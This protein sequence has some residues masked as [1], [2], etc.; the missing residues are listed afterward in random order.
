M[1]RLLALS[2]GIAAAWTAPVQPQGGAAPAAQPQQVTPPRA[3][4]WMGATTGGGIL[5]MAGAGQGR[6]S[7][8]GM[9]R[10]LANPGDASRTV[11]LRLGTSL[12]PQGE[13]DALHTMPPSARVNRPIVLGSKKWPGPGEDPGYSPPKGKVS[14]Y[15]GCGEHVGA[16]QPVVLTFDTLLRGETDPDLEALRAAVT[17]RAVRKPTPGN[18][19]TY[20]EWPHA[21]PRNRN[22]DL[23]ATFPQGSTLA[24]R[25]TVEG[26]Y[27]LPIDFTL[28]QTFMEPVRYVTSTVAPS[29]S[30]PVSWNAVGRATG[31]SLGI[32]GAE[33]DKDDAGIVM[34]SS[35]DRPATFIQMEDLAP[36]EVTRL[37]GLKAVLPP[38]TTSCAIPA[39]VVKAT[40][41]GSLLMFTAFGDEATFIYPPRP[42]DPRTSWNQEWF[43]R[44]SFKSVRMDGITPRGIAEMGGDA[45]LD[46]SP[47]TDTLTDEEYCRTLEDG[48]RNRPSAGDVLGGTGGRLGR[49]LGGRKREEPAD[50]RC[51]KR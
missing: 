41:A 13:A 40:K 6:P 47:T 15:W 8:G 42:E 20:G 43:A 44:A 16:N 17:A 33:S 48:R 35:A 26:T 22:K 5:A 19:T 1:R 24:G 9:L 45:D 3:R 31:Y 32:M 21:D 36:A 51:V 27:T 18:S 39:E 12:S 7:V 2:I 25:H 28:N 34:W 14:F 4:Y 46:P 49:L 11:E 10:G 23:Q 29:G 38:R 50:P 37:I 30:L